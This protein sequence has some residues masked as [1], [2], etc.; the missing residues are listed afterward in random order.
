[1]YG[2]GLPDNVEFLGPLSSADVDRELSAADVFCL[3]SLE[4]GS[5][6]F[7]GG[8]GRRPHVCGDTG[9]VWWRGAG[10]QK[11]SFGAPM[12]VRALVTALDGIS[13]DRSRLQ[14]WERRPGRLCRMGIPGETMVTGPWQLTRCSCPDRSR[15]QERSHHR[16]S[17]ARQQSDPA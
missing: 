17:P 3:P 6:V 15:P 12:D 5:F 14:Y 4:E 9:G 1:M 2:E 11:R 16:Y 8:D 7:A 13:A 10:R